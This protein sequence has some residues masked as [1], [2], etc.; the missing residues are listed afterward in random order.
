MSA[1]SD[2]RVAVVSLLDKPHPYAR[3]RFLSEMGP[4][5]NRLFVPR[6]HWRFSS[7]LRNSF[8]LTSFPVHVAPVDPLHAAIFHVNVERLRDRDQ[9]IAGEVGEDFTLRPHRGRQG[10]RQGE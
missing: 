9:L 8:L 7:G 6:C 5:P 1:L 4:C 10:K 3:S 2:R